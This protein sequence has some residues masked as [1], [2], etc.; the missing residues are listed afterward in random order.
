MSD[1][2]ILYRRKKHFKLLVEGEY[3]SNEIKIKLISI[4]YLHA[5]NFRD[6]NKACEEGFQDPGVLQEQLW[7]PTSLSGPDRWHLLRCLPGRKS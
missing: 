2:I 1:R 3:L 4:V 6:E 7:V 5:Q